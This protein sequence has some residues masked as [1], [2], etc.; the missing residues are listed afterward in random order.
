MDTL[1]VMTTT[2]TILRL[3]ISYAHE[4]LPIAT[5]VAKCLRTALGNVF[6]I[7]NID[8]SFLEAGID[9]R[10]QIKARL[11]ESD[12][13]ISLYTGLDK[14][15]PAWEIGYFEGLT[16]HRQVDRRLVPIFFKKPPPA[17]AYYQGLDLDVP[18]EHL[19]CT[20]DDFKR[21]NTTIGK[22]HPMCRFVAEL[23]EVTDQYRTAA[24]FQMAP[25]ETEQE[26]IVCV[27]TMMVEIFN[28][29]RTTVEATF[30]PQKQIVI[31][32]TDL[33]L[34]NSEG[35]LP[36]DAS[37]IP[38]GAGDPMSIFGLTNVERTW[39]KF[40]SEVGVDEHLE[41]WRGA[42]VSVITSSLDNRINVDNS[43]IIVS[44][45][46]EKAYRVILTSALKYYDGKREFNLYFVETLPRGSYGDRHTT[47]LLKALEFACR[48]R[49]MFFER[50]SEFSSTS[51]GITP[52]NALRTVAAKLVRELNLLKKDA[53]EA[54]LDQ[55]AVWL[56]LVGNCEHF[57]ATVQ[58]YQP[59][60]KD[61]RSAASRI[62]ES[63]GNDEA[64]GELKA[65]L[66]AALQDLE[67]KTADNNAQI[68]QHMTA[69]LQKE[70]AADGR[71]APTS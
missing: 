31:R 39:E 43:Q 27:Q 62:L 59:T 5:A 21:L 18:P 11:E 40:L 2:A 30:K 64:I 14:Q 35:E 60:D 52:N 58:A 47:L 36:R 56:E 37:M 33:S 12:V 20:I 23:Q 54:G 24:G 63:R 49:F 29:L 34:K 10:E 66:V 6:A 51:V 61:I 32:T 41:S 55:P 3:F 13:F 4:D 19:Q 71:H 45:S 1:R 53:R 22:D 57:V 46:A 8:R 17:I 9:F 7:V 68:I 70:T 42:I 26:P 15:W 28:H 50:G 69:K 67:E 25:R 38:V 48:F 65:Q 44:A 16:N